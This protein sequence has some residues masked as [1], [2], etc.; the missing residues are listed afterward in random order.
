MKTFSLFSADIKYYYKFLYSDCAI[1]STA[2]NDQ[3]GNQK[4]ITVVDPREPQGHV[5]SLP[6][7]PKKKQ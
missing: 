2:K 3:E 1:N 6:S 7:S 4:P 5:P